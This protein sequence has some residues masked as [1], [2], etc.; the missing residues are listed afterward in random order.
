MS[1]VSAVEPEIWEFVSCA[2]CHLPYSSDGHGPPSVPFW[3]TDCG[4]VICNNHIQADRS[5]VKCGVTDIEMVPLQREMDQ[6]MADWFRAMPYALDSMAQTAKFQWEMLATLVRFYKAKCIQQRG[7]IDRMKAEY[8][9]HQ[10]Q[11]KTINDLRAENEQLRRTMDY[12]TA[13]SAVSINSNGKRRM[14]D[15]YR[16]AGLSEVG[17]YSSPRSAATPVGPSRLTIP[18]GQPQPVFSSRTGQ[19]EVHGQPHERPGSSLFRQQYA[20]NSDPHAQQPAQNDGFVQ[21]QQKRRSMG[22]P[23]PPPPQRTNVQRSMPPP[24]DPRAPRTHSLVHRSTDAMHAPQVA[25]TPSRS[26]RFQPAATPVLPSQSASSSRYAPPP[27][28]GRSSTSIQAT[29]RGAGVHQTPRGGG[30]QQAPRGSMQQAP[31]QRSGRF[32]PATNVTPAQGGTLHKARSASLRTTAQR[33]PFVPGAQ[34]G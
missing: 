25:A 18:P 22:P 15:A 31:S 3:L 14:T 7:L 1:T 33:A 21:Q 17:G 29:P 27:Q 24:P 4:H 12:H 9:Q 23:P 30:M 32:N 5:C 11:K 6:P 8:R 34:F 19:R 20:Y 16:A 28:Q 26:F 13:N 2:K 10:E